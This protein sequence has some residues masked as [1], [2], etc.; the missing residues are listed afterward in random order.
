M[1]LRVL[2]QHH[3]RYQSVDTGSLP[4]RRIFN[5]LNAFIGGTQACFGSVLRSSE[6]YPY[7]TTGLDDYPVRLMPDQPADLVE[8]VNVA[9]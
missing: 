7:P 3:L 9:S 5:K 1:A 2:E 8:C 4:K 6:A